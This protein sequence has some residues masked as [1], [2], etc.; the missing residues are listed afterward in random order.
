MSGAPALFTSVGWGAP[1]ALKGSAKASAQLSAAR[2][3]VKG[4]LLRV[5]IPFTPQAGPLRCLA[6]RCGA[7]VLRAGTDYGAVPEYLLDRDQVRR[8]RRLPGC[9]RR[10]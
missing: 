3:R 2:L 5:S 6:T 1:W 7:Q 10:P 8:R 4:F 9:R